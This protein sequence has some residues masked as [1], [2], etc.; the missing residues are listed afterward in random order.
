MTDI[1]KNLSAAAPQQFSENP[2]AFFL[3]QSLTYKLDRG[4]AR[5]KKTRPLH[6]RKGGQQ[7]RIFVILERD[8][9]PLLVFHALYRRA[10]E[11]EEEAAAAAATGYPLMAPCACASLPL[12]PQHQSRAA[13]G[14]RGKKTHAAAAA[15]AL[16]IN[17]KEMKQRDMQRG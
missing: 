3:P 2:S 13:E 9:R 17:R 8:S 15:A 14:A 12:A 16:Q 4:N 7:Q 11:D 5:R 1:V 10:T 6:H